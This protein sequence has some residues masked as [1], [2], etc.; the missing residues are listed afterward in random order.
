MKQLA[1]FVISAAL[2]GGL[3]A[4][5]VAQDQDEV[6]AQGVIGD[7]IDKMIGTRYGISD[8]QAV[9]RCGAAAVTKAERDYRPSFR[10]RRHHAYPGYPG[11]VQ[12]VAITDVD[13]RSGG[14]VRVR[15]LLDTGGNGYGYGRRGADVMFRC[16]TDR[17]GRVDTVILQRNPY[18]R[19][20]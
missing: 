1:R 8:R 4:P 6:G 11:Y 3:A 17:R 15:G 20:R 19:L 9:R 13:R 12:I 5:A 10:G 18:Y 7:V 14:R 16:D 2:V